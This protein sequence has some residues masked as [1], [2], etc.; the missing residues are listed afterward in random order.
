MPNANDFNISQFEDR[1]PKIK[2]LTQLFFLTKQYYFF[3]I[4]GCVANV[5]VFSF[6]LHS[7]LRYIEKTTG[8]EE[9]FI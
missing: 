7:T 5:C 9:I 6:V 1:N 4:V 2:L 8:T 3:L